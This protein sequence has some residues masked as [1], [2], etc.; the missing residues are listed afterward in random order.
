MTGSFPIFNLSAAF[1]E[2]A[3][4]W[5]VGLGGPGLILLGILD[6]LPFISAP[7]GSTDVLV[8]M[9]AAG[10]HDWWA[11]YALMASIGEVFGGYLTFRLAKVGGQAMLEKERIGKGRAESI[12]GSFEKNGSATVLVGSLLPPPFPFT[13][14][15]IV[16]G[17]LNYP[18]R[19]FLAALAAGRLLRFFAIAVLGRIY[20]RQIIDVFA[21]HHRVILVV[22]AVLAVAGVFAY[23]VWYRPKKQSHHSQTSSLNSHAASQE[24]PR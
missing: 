12:Y 19:R 16:A 4:K 14:I 8:I 17:L 13:P 10:H 21:A 3:W 2:A 20:G 9:L 11:Y 7:P 1:H 23:F 24:S 22:L 6:N 15:I 18:R 5:I